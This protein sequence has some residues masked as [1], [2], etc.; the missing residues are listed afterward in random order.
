M[1][2]INYRNTISIESNK[3]K[4]F[5]K[6]DTNDIFWLRSRKSITDWYKAQKPSEFRIIQ[7]E[8]FLTLK[9]AINY[10]N[11]D[12]QIEMYVG[13]KPDTQP[14]EPTDVSVMR[15]PKLDLWIISTHQHTWFQITKLNQFDLQVADAFDSVESKSTQEHIWK[16][17]ET[18]RIR[19]ER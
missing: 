17:R 15:V 14:N 9:D 7:K 11:W 4:N 1:N 19:S 16:T 8:Q 6:T 12:L 3:K 5:I 13:M 2:L 18:A 10:E